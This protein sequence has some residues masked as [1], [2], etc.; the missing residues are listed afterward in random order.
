MAQLQ[1]KEK[2]GAVD[3]SKI[4]YASFQK[5]FYVEVPEISKMSKDA[6]K[7]Y[8][9]QLEGIRVRGKDIP[10]PIKTWVQAGVSARLLNILKKW[11]YFLFDGK[12]SI[13]YYINY[14]IFLLCNVSEVVLKNLRQSSVRRCPLLCLDAT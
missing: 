1:K 6:V 2:L 10:K 8:R 9:L 4:H 7:K 13:L 12:Q 3:H 14:A 11:V 5:N